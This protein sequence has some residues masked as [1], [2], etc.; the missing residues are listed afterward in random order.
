MMMYGRPS[1]SVPKLKMS[2][3]LRW[4]MALTA[5][6]S[7]TSRCTCVSSLANSGLSTL[8]ATRFLMIGCTPRYTMPM[9]PSPTGSRMRYSPT[10]IPM[11]GSSSGGA[12]GSAEG[13]DDTSTRETEQAIALVHGM[14]CSRRTTGRTM[15]AEVRWVA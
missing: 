9:P 8:M 13:D 11:S 5:A 6:A 3:M 1:G 7:A 4:P 10:W 2:M 15:S 12:T 14:C